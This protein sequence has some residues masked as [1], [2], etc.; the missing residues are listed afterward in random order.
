MD[1]LG[2]GPLYLLYL[3]QIVRFVI[4]MFNSKIFFIA[5]KV[6]R[7]I[8]DFYSQKMQ[9]GPFQRTFSVGGAMAPLAPPVATPLYLT[10]DEFQTTHPTMVILQIIGHCFC[11]QFPKPFRWPFYNNYQ[12]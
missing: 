12:S 5:N 10:S 2:F 6:K 3:K 9:S 8:S 1:L 11:T 7:L 4:I